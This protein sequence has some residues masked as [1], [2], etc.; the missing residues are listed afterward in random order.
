M[1]YKVNKRLIGTKQVRPSSRLPSAYQEVEYIGSSWTQYIN[2]WYTP[3][4]SFNFEIKYYITSKSS[5]VYY[6]LFGARNSEYSTGSFYL[7]YYNNYCFYQ[8]P[9]NFV[10]N[11]TSINTYT[12]NTNLQLSYKNWILSDGTNSKSITYTKAPNYNLTIF[13]WNAWWTISDMS[14]YR[15]YS[16]KMYNWTTLVRDFVPC[17]RKSDNV[18]WLYDLVNNQI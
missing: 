18:I 1:W 4:T 6:A 11:E 16:F 9:P 13:G 14:S 15:L 17:Y 12:S 10:Y 2:T 8:I 7:W 5:N 3:T